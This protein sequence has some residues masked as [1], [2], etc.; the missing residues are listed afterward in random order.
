MT[1]KI[2]AFATMQDEV[3]KEWRV[4]IYNYDTREEAQKAIEEY[5]KRYKGGFPRISY[6]GA[7]SYYIMSR[8]EWEKIPD[9]YK[10]TSIRDNSIKT[11]FEGSIPG[12]H[13]E[14]GTTLLFEGLHFEIL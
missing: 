11:V 2:R 1:K 7:H 9:N 5:T 10:G 12:N 6:A 4:N 3:G 8:D 14:G 13:G